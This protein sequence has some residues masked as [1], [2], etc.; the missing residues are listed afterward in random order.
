MNGG[1]DHPASY[2]I[3]QIGFDRGTWDPVLDDRAT[4]YGRGRWRLLR[5][6]RLSSESLSHPFTSAKIKENSKRKM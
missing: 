5:Q 3:D 1:D 2:T 6:D 4:E